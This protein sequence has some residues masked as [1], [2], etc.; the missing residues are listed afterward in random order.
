MPSQS[1]GTGWR[2]EEALAARWSGD[3]SFGISVGLQ[4]AWLELGDRLTPSPPLHPHE[5]LEVKGS[6]ALQ[7]EVSGSP[8]AMGEDRER[9]PL[10]VLL[11]QTMDQL[12]AIRALGQEEHGGLGEGPLQMGVAIFARWCP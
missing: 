9:L 5:A 10:A 2:A 8:D 3:R 12:L 6:L 7:H 1:I 4:R 11:R